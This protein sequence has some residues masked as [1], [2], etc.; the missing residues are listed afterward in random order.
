M[1]FIHMNQILDHIDRV[2]QALQA[3][4]TYIRKAAETIYGLTNTL[5]PIR[6]SEI[7]DF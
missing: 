5:Q 6:D 3:K 7:E 4:N 2:N 1:Y